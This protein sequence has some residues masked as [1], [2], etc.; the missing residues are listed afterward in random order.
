MSSN[1]TIPHVGV[2][3]TGTLVHTPEESPGQRQLQESLHHQ[4]T[5]KNS[6][7]LSGEWI[8]RWWHVHTKEGSAARKMT[9][10]SQVQQRNLLNS[11]DSQSRGG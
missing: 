6:N 8:H 11:K 2:R 7:V 4:K 3:P 10:S 5:G 1:P 9:D